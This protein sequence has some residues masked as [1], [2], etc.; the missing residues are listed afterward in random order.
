MGQMTLSVRLRRADWLQVAERL[1]EVP[2]KSAA[3]HL[4]GVE[5]A[6]GDLHMVPRS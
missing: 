4:R 5:A 6:N 2:A 1:A 3:E